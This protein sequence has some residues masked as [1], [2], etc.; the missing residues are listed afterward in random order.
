MADFK[1]SIKILMELEFNN[2]G[3]ALHKNKTESGYTYMGIYQKAHPKWEGWKIVLEYLE[4]YKNIKIASKNLYINEPLT[5]LVNLFYKKTFW[6]KANLDLINSQKISN[7]IFIFGV[8]SGMPVA[9]KTAQ[10][11]VGISPDGDVRAKTIKTLNNFDE[12]VFDAEYDLLEQKHYA[13]L[14]ERNPK[15]KIY[16]NGWRNRSIA[17]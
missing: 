2:P 8:N 14:I 7:E 12:K 13:M 6:D 15:L 1:D 11:L 3:N 17:V 4:K 9:I 16:A 10:K 5:F